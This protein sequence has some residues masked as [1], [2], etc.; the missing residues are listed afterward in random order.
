MIHS[1][2]L[3]QWLYF[4]KC[5]SSLADIDQQVAS[6]IEDCYRLHSKFRMFK[7]RQK[8]EYIFRCVILKG[9]HLEYRNVHFLWAFQIVI[10]IYTSCTYLILVYLYGRCLSLHYY[11]FIYTFYLLSTLKWPLHTI[12]LK[13]S[14]WQRKTQSWG[15]LYCREFHKKY[16]L[17]IPIWHFQNL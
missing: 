13:V 2:Y 16:F 15:A 12:Y 6:E 14:H 17:N 11:V 9:K 3:N 4:I 10:F 7:Q 1:N 8:A 5:G